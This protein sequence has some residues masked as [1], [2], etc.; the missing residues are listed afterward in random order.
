MP[1]IPPNPPVGIPVDNR[2]VLARKGPL[3]RAEAARP[4]A[5]RAVLSGWFRDG[6]LR[7]DELRSDSLRPNTRMQFTPRIVYTDSL[8]PPQHTATSERIVT[9][10]DDTP[11]I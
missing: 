11:I 4:C 2:T 10:S 6:R 8:T 1:L 3:R 7:R 5:L 9:A